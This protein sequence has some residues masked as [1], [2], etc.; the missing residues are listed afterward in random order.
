VFLQRIL[1]YILLRGELT[2]GPLFILPFPRL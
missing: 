1:V 2:F